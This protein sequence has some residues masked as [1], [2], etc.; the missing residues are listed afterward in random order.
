MYTVDEKQGIVTCTLKCYG[1]YFT[2]K[3][4]ANFDEGEVFDEEI[5]KKIA[6]Y[7][8]VLKMRKALLKSAM[9]DLAY[10]RQIASLEEQVQDYIRKTTEN[11][12]KVEQ[13]LN[14]I[15]GIEVPLEE[16]KL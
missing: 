11:Y 10:I 15:L 12:F 9:N 4:K 6:K 13:Q 5:G 14:D 8:A 7:R 16:V 1:V 2:G 3:A